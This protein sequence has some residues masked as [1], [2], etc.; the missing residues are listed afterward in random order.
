[1]LQNILTAIMVMAM[2]ACW[3]IVIF[4]YQTPTGRIIIWI[5]I[6]VMSIAGIILN[7]LIKEDQ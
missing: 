1:M 3:A 6:I 4:F 2:I 7:Y 5:P